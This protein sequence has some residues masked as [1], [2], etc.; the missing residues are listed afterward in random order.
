MLRVRWCGIVSCPFASISFMRSYKKKSIRIAL[1]ST[2]GWFRLI[3]LLINST[4]QMLQ[5][6][7]HCELVEMFC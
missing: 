1:I 6:V 2:S 4:H 5:A 3:S 7:H